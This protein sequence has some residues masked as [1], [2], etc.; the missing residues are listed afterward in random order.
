MNLK[1]NDQEM[2]IFAQYKSRTE[3]H[4]LALQKK[5]RMAIKFLEKGGMLKA[6]INKD[7][8][9]VHIECYDKG[10]YDQVLKGFQSV[11]QMT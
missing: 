11:A 3:F 8:L 6:E 9:T 5:M 10:I 7:E 4:K 2:T 1:T